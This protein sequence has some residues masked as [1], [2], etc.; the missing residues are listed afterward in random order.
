V[1]V[2]DG[3]LVHHGGLGPGGVEAAGTEGV[4]V[5]DDRGARVAHHH[6]GLSVVERPLGQ[7]AALGIVVDHGLRAVTCLGR[8]DQRLELGLGPIDVPAGVVAVLGSVT[9]GDCVYLVVEAAILP[10][11]V[12]HHV[13]VQQRVIEG[14]VEDVLLVAGAAGD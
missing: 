11:R 6:V 4:I 7:L 8:R 2:D 12:A 14:G 1:V 10:V 13:G 3:A 5:G 9:G